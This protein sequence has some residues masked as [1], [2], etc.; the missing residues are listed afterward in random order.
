MIRNIKTLVPGTFNLYE[1][2]AE[3][4]AE[5]ARQPWAIS[6]S[7]LEESIPAQDRIRLLRLVDDTSGGDATYA[8]SRPLFFYIRADAPQA[9]AFV[10]FVLGSEAQAKTYEV[11]LYPEQDADS[12]PL[13]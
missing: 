7:D 2:T 13:K 12:A 11:A 1:H 10:D 9:E 3:V 5:V 4:V 8:L 6:F